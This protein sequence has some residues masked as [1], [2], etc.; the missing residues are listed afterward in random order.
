MEDYVC[1]ECGAPAYKDSRM[2]SM[3]VVLVCKCADRKVWIDDG[4]GGY[5]FCKAEPITPREFE[6]KHSR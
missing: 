1:S 6:S 5:Y 4:R 2:G 3:D